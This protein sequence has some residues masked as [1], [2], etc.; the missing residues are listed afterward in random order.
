MSPIEITTGFFVFA[1]SISL[2]ISSAA[3]GAARAVHPEH[4]GFDRRVVS[5]LPSW[6]PTYSLPT[7]SSFEKSPVE[8]CLPYG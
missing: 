1:Y 2:I 4:D 3:A 5:C 7:L 6:L 8:T